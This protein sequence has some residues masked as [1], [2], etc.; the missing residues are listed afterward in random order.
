MTYIPTTPCRCSQIHNPR[1]GGWDSLKLACSCCL[2]ANIPRQ[3][4]MQTQK[5]TSYSC[6]LHPLCGPLHN[7]GSSHNSDSEAVRT[8]PRRETSR[9]DCVRVRYPIRTRN[10]ML[11]PQQRSMRRA[12]FAKR[13][14]NEDSEAVDGELPCCFFTNDGTQHF[15]EGGGEPC[16]FERCAV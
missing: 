11:L 5:L 7:L 9:Y 2:E 13:R 8:S 10:L 16:G 1:L 3:A 15:V 12:G 6:S 14:S 4:R